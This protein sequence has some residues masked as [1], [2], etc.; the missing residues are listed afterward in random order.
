MPTERKLIATEGLNERLGVYFVAES[1]A[2]MDGATV[3]GPVSSTG[4]LDMATAWYRVV[5]R[6]DRRGPRAQP[7]TGKL[8]AV[9]YGPL[10]TA[11]ILSPEEQERVGR[12]RRAFAK[13][14]RTTN[15]RFV[16]VWDATL[17][18]DV[19]VRA[20]LKGLNIQ[21]ARSALLAAEGA[22]H[23][24]ERLGLDLPALPAGLPPERDK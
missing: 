4:E 1:L 19:V 5:L 24:A 20:D 16:P 9:S 12:E 8:W 11:A 6:Y 10:L 15:W 22:D 13:L 3:Y 14:M 2:H 17:D 21:A 7:K 18:G 23:Y